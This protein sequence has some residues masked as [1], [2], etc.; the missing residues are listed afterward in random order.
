MSPG[1]A[2][3]NMKMSDS[4]LIKGAKALGPWGLSCWRLAALLAGQPPEAFGFFRGFSE[5]LPMRPSVAP[6]SMKI[7]PLRWRGAGVGCS[8]TGRTHP[9]R[10][11]P[12]APP[13]RGF[14][15]E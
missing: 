9:R 10:L 6:L 11:R 14:S 3:P 5:E 7:I 8:G 15:E 4:P 2:L 13:K 1:A 12:S